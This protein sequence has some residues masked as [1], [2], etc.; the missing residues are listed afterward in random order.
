VNWARI[1]TPIKSGSLRVRNLIQFNRALL[2]KW[3][4]LYGMDREALWRLV[5]ET[6]YDRSRGCWCFKEVTGTFGVSLKA[7]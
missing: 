6:K 7:Y 5:V 2:R 1:C 3:L 4:W